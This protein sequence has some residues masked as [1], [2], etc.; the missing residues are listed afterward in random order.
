MWLMQSFYNLT[1]SWGLSI[2]LLTVLVRI[3]M[4]PLTQKQMVS[5]QRMQKL[6][7]MLKVLQEKYQ[8]D[9]ETLNREVMALYKENK[10]NPASGCLPLLIQLPIF[11]LLYGVLSRHGFAGATFFWVQLDGSVLT[12]IAKAINLVNE[13]GVPLPK[14]QLGFVVVV[15]SAMTNPKMLFANLGVW[16]PNTILLLIIAFLTWYQQRVS[17]SGNPQ[18]S[19][20][21]W[22]MPLFLTFICLSLPGGVLL[23]WGVSS[24]MGVVHQLH[25]LRRT[26]KEMQQKPQLFQEKPRKPVSQGDQG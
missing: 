6:Q 13:A 19:M 18:M 7:P 3:A 2:I 11:I 24:L 26:N 4:H 9:K 16:L 21:N 25:V 14:E 10:V 8:D 12:T 20:M 17:S 22:F 1:N 5:M 23:Y 15:F